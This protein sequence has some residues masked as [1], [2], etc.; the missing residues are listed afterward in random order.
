MKLLRYVFK[1]RG[2]EL[3]NEEGLTLLSSPKTH[4]VNIT[5]NL[6]MTLLRPGENYFYGLM[7]G[8]KQMRQEARTVAGLFHN[9]RDMLIY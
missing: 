2:W 7:S 9:Y 8:N 3:A 6:V 1:N 5:S 4:L